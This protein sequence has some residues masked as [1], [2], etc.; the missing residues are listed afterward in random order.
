MQLLSKCTGKFSANLVLLRFFFAPFYKKR[1]L[2]IGRV[3][4]RKFGRKVELG[5]QKYFRLNIKYIAIV[6]I[7]VF[8]KKLIMNQHKFLEELNNT[9]DPLMFD[10]EGYFCFEGHII[11]DI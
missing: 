8:E 1:P 2:G 6:G 9:K 10:F 4:Y 7:C 3:G 5:V 11:V